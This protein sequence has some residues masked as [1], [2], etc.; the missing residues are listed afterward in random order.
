MSEDRFSNGIWKHIYKLRLY[1]YSTVLFPVD[2][3]IRQVHCI[4]S[5][6][7]INHARDIINLPLYEVRWRKRS[8][9]F[10][11]KLFRSLS[12]YQNRHPRESQN[13]D[14]STS[15]N[16]YVTVYQQFFR[17]MFHLQ[18]AFQP[19]KKETNAQRVSKNTHA[20][21]TYSQRRII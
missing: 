12:L 14:S 17:H 6:G 18:I 19:K 7:K 4:M 10:R 21:T 1:A 20:S 11:W 16:S 13:S 9:V 2:L 3:Y 8:C 5:S 15:C